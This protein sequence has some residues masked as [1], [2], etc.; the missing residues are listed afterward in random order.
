MGNS[1]N[2]LTFLKFIISVGGSHCDN[3]PY[4]PRTLD[5]PLHVGDGLIHVVCSV[6]YEF[7]SYN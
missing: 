7:S 6:S 2:I 5:T 4:A 3:S 1:I